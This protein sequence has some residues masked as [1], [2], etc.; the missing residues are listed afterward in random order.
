MYLAR[1][2]P[3]YCLLHDNH[4]KNRRKRKLTVKTN[5]RFQEEAVFTG[6]LWWLLPWF[7]HIRSGISRGNGGDLRPAS[8]RVDQHCC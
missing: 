8:T 5:V 1:Y 4:R 6:L 7:P 2:R 3:D